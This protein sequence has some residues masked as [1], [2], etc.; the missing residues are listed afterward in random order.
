MFL[1]FEQRYAKII[2]FLNFRNKSCRQKF[3]WIT[4]KSTVDESKITKKYCERRITYNAVLDPLIVVVGPRA[5]QL[6]WKLGQ[7]DIFVESADRNVDWL[8]SKQ[9]QNSA[10][11]LCKNNMLSCSCVFISKN[12]RCKNE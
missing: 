5:T 2:C 11:N 8:K 10:V 1:Q 3:R 4:V 12:T 7:V 6:F 9:T